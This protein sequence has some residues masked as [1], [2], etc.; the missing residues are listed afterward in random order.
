MLKSQ[1]AIKQEGIVYDKLRKKGLIFFLLIKCL[2]STINISL[3][4][5]IK[6][7]GMFCDFQKVF[8]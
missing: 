5:E 1:S 3:D 2:N 4:S 6:G 8:Q 7:N